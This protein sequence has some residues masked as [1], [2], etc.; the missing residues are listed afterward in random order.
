MLGILWD[1]ASWEW[2]LREK[3]ETSEGARPHLEP[4]RYGGRFAPRPQRAGLPPAADLNPRSTSDRPKLSSATLLA[5][6]EAE[7]MVLRNRAVELALRIQKLAEPQ[8]WPV[9]MR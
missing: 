2:A 3:T 7:N 4:Y 5:R 8:R 1:V 6:L 9:N